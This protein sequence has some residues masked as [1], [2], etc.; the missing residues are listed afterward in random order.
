V[1]DRKFLNQY[2]NTKACATKTA[3]IPWVPAK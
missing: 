2:S 3:I 1:L